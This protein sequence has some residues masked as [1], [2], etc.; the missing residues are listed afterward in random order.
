LQKSIRSLIEQWKSMIEE[1]ELIFVYAPSYNKNI[2]YNYEGAVLKKGWFV[3][4]VARAA[5]FEC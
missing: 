3:F 1:S 2:I 4:W 5:S